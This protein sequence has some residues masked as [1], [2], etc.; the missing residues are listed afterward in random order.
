M[1]PPIAVSAI[2]T[3]LNNALPVKARASP[4]STCLVTPLRVMTSAS[5]SVGI[6]VVVVV[7]VVDGTTGRMMVV[8]GAAMVVDG[9]ATIGSSVGVVVDGITTVS[10]THLTL[11]TKRIV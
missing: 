11:P 6:D 10:Y 5:T 9:S 3:K 4:D 1:P 8:G 7:A 2:S